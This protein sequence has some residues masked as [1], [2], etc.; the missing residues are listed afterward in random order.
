MERLLQLELL[1]NLF[2]WKGDVEILR[3][4]FSIDLGCMQLLGENPQAKLSF[5]SDTVAST[6]PLPIDAYV[7]AFHRVSEDFGA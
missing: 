2:E 5:E 4:V 3:S 1:W 7:M 6:Q